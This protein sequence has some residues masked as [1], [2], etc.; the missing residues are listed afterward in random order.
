MYLLYIYTSQH[1]RPR[2]RPRQHISIE[3]EPIE[4]LQ[5]LP[6]HR[7]QRADIDLFKPMY[8]YLCHIKLYVRNYGKTIN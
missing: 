4:I 1:D 7:L 2:K 8:T 3:L 6:R 5:P